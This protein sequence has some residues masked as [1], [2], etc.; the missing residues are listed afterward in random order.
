[1]S[2]RIPSSLK[3]LID[4]RA[5]LDA[6]IRKTQ[7]SIA[8]NKELIKELSSLKKNLSAI[9]KALELH[10]ISVDVTLIEPVKSHYKRIDLPHGELTSSILGAG[11]VQASAFHRHEVVAGRARP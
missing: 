5:R 4:K 11:R 9:D 10:E 8:K 2:T 6:E 3:W 7:S 1:M